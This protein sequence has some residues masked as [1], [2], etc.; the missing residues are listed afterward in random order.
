MLSSGLRNQLEAAQ[1]LNQLEELYR[2]YRQKKKTRASA[3]REAG[4]EP[5]ASAIQREARAGGGALENMAMQYVRGSIKDVQA[6]LSG[7]RDIIAEGVTEDPQ[8]RAQGQALLKRRGRISSSPVK[9][10]EDEVQRVALAKKYRTYFA[11][12]CPL[13]SIRPHQILAL[14]RGQGEKVLHVKMELPA[15][16]LQPA[17]ERSAGLFAQ[18]NG[19]AADQVRAAVADGIKRLLW[20]SIER[21]AWS[22]LKQEAAEAAKKEFCINLRALLMQPPLQGTVVLG[23]DPGFASG[24]KMAVCGATGTVLHTSVIYPFS[25]GANRGGSRAHEELKDILQRYGVEVVSIGDGTASRDTEMLVS[26]VL[27]ELSDKKMIKC[28]YAIVS[29]AGASVYSTSAGAASELPNLDC[30]L[31]GA[32]SIARRLQDPLAEL[33]KIDPNAIGVGMYQHDLDQRALARSL[34]GVVE[35]VVNAVGVNPNSASA[36]LLA[37]VAGIGPKLGAA[38]VAHRDTN[39]PFSTRQ[40]LL[41]VKGLGKKTF[42]QAAGFLRIHGGSE[43]LDAT[44]VHPE[45]YKAFGTLLQKYEQNDGNGKCGAQLALKERLPL[46][47]L[48]GKVPQVAK[49]LKVGELTLEDILNAIEVPGLDPRADVA[50][51][52]LRTGAMSASELK[53]GGVIAGTVRNVVPFGAFVDVGVKQDGLVHISQLANR[54]IKDPHEVVTPGDIVQVRVTG[55]DTERGRISLSMKNI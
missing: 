35:S 55:V 52:L 48:R 17:A 45:C 4:L 32:V 37:Y 34:G 14:M 39:G 21:L 5:L 2:P 8:L 16:D 51:P 27:K 15:D 26:Q 28:R 47:E 7:A 44:A 13:P 19:A 49:E 40:D 36:P 33:V 43:E 42:E 46:A 50:E 54:R 6:A 18:S 23:L 53:I 3:A 20:P 9:I 30:T 22:E 11:F 10:P 25:T 1:T 38:I 12:S 24:C 29:E 41:K 31:R